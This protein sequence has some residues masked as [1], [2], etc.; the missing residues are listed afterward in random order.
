MEMALQQYAA[1]FLIARDYTLVQ[2]P[3]MMN[4]EAYEGV[5]DLADFETV[6]YGVEPDKFYLIAVSGCSLVAMR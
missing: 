5:T 1:N 6:M 3:L 2:P 4:R